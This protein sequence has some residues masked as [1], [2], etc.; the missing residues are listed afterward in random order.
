MSAANVIPFAGARPANKLECALALA[1]AGFHVFPLAPDTKNKPLITDYPNKAS[2]DPEQI[3]KWGAQWP[4][5]NVAISTTRYGAG[6][7]LVVDVDNKGDKDGDS[8]TLAL[9]LDGRE[10]PPT[11]VQHTP[12]GGRHVIYTV[13]KAVKQGVD[14]LGPGLDIRSHGGYIVGAG[15]VVPAG[16]YSATIQTPAP[17]PQWLID[18]CGA[19]RERTEDSAKPVE[20]VDIGRARQ[21]ASEYLQTAPQAVEGQGG[22]ATTFKV[23]ARVKDLGVP[24]DEAADVLAPWNELNAPPWSPDE[25]AVKIRNAYKYGT[26]RPGAA[27]AEAQFDAVP[28]ADA[29][30]YTPAW[31]PEMN[32]QFFVV[33]QGGRVLV[34]RPAYDDALRRHYLERISFE[35]LRRMFQNKLV[36]VIGPSSKPVRVDQA[37]AWLDHPKRRQYLDGVAF[38][39]GEETP[40]G[41]F[42]L[43]RG[44]AIEPKA[45]DWSLMREHIRQII[46]GDDEMAFQYV[47]GWLARL[48]QLPGEQGQVA[49]ALKGQKGVG[50]GTLGEALAKIFGQH[51]LH[52]SNA[53][54]LIG[55]FNGH[56]RDACFIFGDECFYAGDKQHESTLKTLI[57]E[58]FIPI[59]AKYQE[60]VMAR[61]VAHVLLASNSDWMVPASADE[62]RFCVLNVSDARRGDRQY[63]NA[64]RREMDA[65]GIAAMLHDLLAYDL[66]TFDV[67]NVPQTEAL[68][69]EKLQTMRGVDLWLFNCLQRGQI[70][71][72]DWTEQ[73]ITLPNPN[74]PYDVYVAAIRQSR[75]YAP[76]TM[77]V[78][79]KAM[80]KALGD[81]WARPQK[82]AG[83]KRTRLLVIGGL[84]EARRAFEEHVGHLIEWP[85]DA[86]DAPA[87]LGR[88]GIFDR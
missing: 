46:C 4:A 51:G 37:K 66:S 74:E 11:M 86:V 32:E 21:R 39:P 88:G 45:G 15:S 72:Q 13:P 33:N 65:G 78:W 71:S 47:L 30:E 76:K 5:A 19:R 64:L 52:L 34:Y 6:G 35:D 56:L 22:D 27:A 77:D 58:R 59:E 43:W 1:A 73:G 12:T 31:L 41:K 85:T 42:N 79:S 26:E 80:A 29:K 84:S 54:H 28:E 20:G 81:C 55:R 24:Q 57:T 40:P 68:A 63:F 53:E 62:R 87:G 60:P 14:V 69:E 16:V 7:L 10:F 38:L 17:A 83:H 70:G 44:F 8:A 49:V 3:R 61:N 36:T 67:F 25:L 9:E 18:A 75:E 23:V 2:R 50:K 82:R 48:V